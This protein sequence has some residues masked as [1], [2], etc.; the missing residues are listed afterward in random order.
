MKGEINM[1]KNN[2][3]FATRVRNGLKEYHF[4]HRY[5][6][7]GEHITYFGALRIPISTKQQEEKFI[8]E[9]TRNLA[10]MYHLSIPKQ[11]PAQKH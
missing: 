8:S 2:I 11:Q 3:E 7:Y 1:M 10:K 4:A 9:I 5:G 6:V